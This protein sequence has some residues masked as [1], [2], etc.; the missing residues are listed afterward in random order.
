MVLLKILVLNVCFWDFQSITGPQG[1]NIKKNKL[2]ERQSE[3]DIQNT[4][5]ILFIL[6]LDRYPILLHWSQFL[7]LPVMIS[8]YLA[9]H[10]TAN[11]SVQ[12]VLAPRQC[13]VEV[14]T[15]G[16]R[17]KFGW[18]PFPLNET[19]VIFAKAERKCDTIGLCF[20]LWSNA[21]WGKWRLVPE[22]R[23]PIKLGSLGL[24]DICLHPQC[25]TAHICK[26]HLG[27]T[28]SRHWQSAEGR[29]E[30]EERIEPVKIDIRKICVLK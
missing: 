2:W 30:G 3:K 5:V 6:S 4:S 12:S 16:S 22:C 17:N 21:A 9:A 28:P 8:G 27:G 7:K 15:N 20:A 18:R 10:V 13:K 11:P 24:E 23:N 29:Q 14:V 1:A 25:L 26:G 19:V